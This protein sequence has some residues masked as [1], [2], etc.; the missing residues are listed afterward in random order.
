MRLVQRVGNLRAVFQHLLQRQCSFFQ[1]LRQRLSLH[2]LHHQIVDPILTANVIQHT[3]VWMIEAGDGLGFALEPL[4]A[5]RISGELCGQNLD[6]D[7]AFESRVPGTIDFAHA[8][9][10]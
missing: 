2:A 3:N 6:R 8:A 4:L 10:A 1:P 9:S 7:S 5:N